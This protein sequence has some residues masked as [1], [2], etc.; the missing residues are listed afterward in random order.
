MMVIG[1]PV[2][3]EIVSSYRL[4]AIATGRLPATL[5][6]AA[7][8]GVLRLSRAILRARTTFSSMAVVA[9]GV[10]TIATTGLVSVRS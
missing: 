3:M 1:L 5:A 8:I 6:L 4:R 7:S 10:G 2:L 9:A